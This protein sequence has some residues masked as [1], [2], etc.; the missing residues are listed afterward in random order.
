MSRELRPEQNEDCADVMAAY[1]FFNWKELTFNAV[2]QLSAGGCGHSRRSRHLAGNQ[3]GLAIDLD[4]QSIWTG[5]K[6]LHGRIE[7][8][9][10]LMS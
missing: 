8:M 6:N 9:K 1:R 10:L 3:S 5:Y 2:T 4:W 7:G